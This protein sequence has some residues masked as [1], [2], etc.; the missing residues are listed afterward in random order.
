MSPTQRASA[1]VFYSYSHKDERLRDDLADALALLKRQSILTEWHDRKIA[2]GDEWEQSI[3]EHIERAD[4]ILLL[5]S[6][7]FIASDYCWGKEVE[8]AMERHKAGEAR[9]IPIVLRPV[10]WNGAMFGKLQALPKNAK[11]ITLWSNRDLAWLDVARGIR[12]A[13]EAP[14]KGPPSKTREVKTREV[15]P[16]PP[17]R[18]IKPTPPTPPAPHVAPRAW[19]E[20]SR[21]VYT[22][23]NGE[24]LP[25]KPVRDEGNVP[26]GDAAINQVYDALGVTYHFFREVFDRN[27]IDGLGMPLV[28]TVHY[29]KNFNNAF[30][31]GK[32]MTFGDGDGKLFKPF[33][34]LDMVAK[35]FANGV[36]SSASKLVYWG[37]S[38]ALLNSMSLVFATLV[39]QFALHQTASQ[40]DWLIGDGVLAGKGAIVSLAAPGTAYDDPIL[41]KDLQPAH[42]RDYLETQDDNGGIHVNAGI[43][44]RAFYL[45][46]V[47]LGGFAWEK[48]GWIWY[49]AL[50]DKKLKSNSQFVDF[51]AMTQLVAARRYGTGSDELRAVK[52]AWDLVGVAERG[53]TRR[54]A[55]VK[56]SHGTTRARQPSPR[57]RTKRGRAK[58]PK[59]AAR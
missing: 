5:V 29:G 20:L 31:N 2:A 9:V 30:W 27:S 45:T 3:D 1:S 57:Q 28:A 8:R 26:T 14:L 15:S 33:T 36:V 38:G 12:A 42:M 46:A 7:V 17:R 25:G 4:I 54:P 49:E 50:R 55:P 18:S 23:E 40:A 41:G 47:A 51:A 16:A 56:G 34:S 32:Q 35:Q 44:N 6:P 43:L 39:K 53:S 21:A 52:N 11:P 59:R 13:V 58:S 24:K 48:A 10:D 19:T 37:Q 22:A